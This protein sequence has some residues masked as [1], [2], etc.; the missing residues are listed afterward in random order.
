MFTFQVN[1]F[2]LLKLGCNECWDFV[3][4]LCNLFPF[5]LFYLY[6]PAYQVLF[7][8]ACE[9]NVQSKQLDNVLDDDGSV[10]NYYV[11]HVS[12]I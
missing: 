9:H 1:A 4:S 8:Y 10:F 3:S 5:E 11:T 12:L 6:A 7:V 2:D